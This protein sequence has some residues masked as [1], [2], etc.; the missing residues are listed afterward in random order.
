M[1]PSDLGACTPWCAVQYAMLPIMSV[2]FLLDFT[3][4]LWIKH[5]R[6][7][8]HLFSIKK[9]FMNI[10]PVTISYVDFSFFLFIT[11]GVGGLVGRGCC[12]LSKREK[13]EQEREKKRLLTFL[14]YKQS[15]TEK[16]PHHNYAVK[17]ID[18]LQHAVLLG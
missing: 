11:R 2:I 1:Q 14:A 18:I 13:N 12:L 15:L 6:L 3:C 17:K 7:M 9:L 4:A 8:R 16:P 10:V 5:L